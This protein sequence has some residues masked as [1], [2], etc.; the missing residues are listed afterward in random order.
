MWYYGC[1]PSIPYA[2]LNYLD[3]QCSFSQWQ[4]YP[5]WLILNDKCWRLRHIV[6][7]SDISNVINKV[8]LVHMLTKLRLRIPYQKSSET[9][10]LSCHHTCILDTMMFIVDAKLFKGIKVTQTSHITSTTTL[11][12]TKWFK[13]VWYIVSTFWLRIS[14]IAILSW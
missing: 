8:Y 3:T 2:Y 9:S 11:H 7:T 6:K 1:F 13:L 4:Y 5:E 10:S 14:P 12:T